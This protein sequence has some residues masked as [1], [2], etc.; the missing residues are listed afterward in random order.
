MVEINYYLHID[1]MVVLPIH[2]LVFICCRRLDA[3]VRSIDTSDDIWK[4]SL[5]V[6]FHLLYICL[7][8]CGETDRS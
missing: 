4:P 7:L 2:V 8:L 1:R 6:E 5:V 3:D